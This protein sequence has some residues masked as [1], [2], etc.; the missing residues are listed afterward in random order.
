[1]VDK[2]FNEK[3]EDIPAVEIS[4]ASS[5]IHVHQPQKRLKAKKY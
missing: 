4:V 5:F 1:M 3:G 2:C